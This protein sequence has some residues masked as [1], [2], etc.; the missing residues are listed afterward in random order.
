[1]ALLKVGDYLPEYLHNRLEFSALGFT[2][3][4]KFLSI[5]TAKSYPIT[6]IDEKAGLYFV[7]AGDVG[8]ID[9]YILRIKDV[10][11]IITEH[12]GRKPGFKNLITKIFNFK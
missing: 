1:M 2:V 12:E 4:A 11:S 8:P 10:D 9:K 6:G 5:W 3:W 7:K